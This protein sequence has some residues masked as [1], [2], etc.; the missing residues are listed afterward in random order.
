MS[1]LRRMQHLFTIKHKQAKQSSGWQWVLPGWVLAR[2]CPELSHA[3]EC[4]LAPPDMLKDCTSTHRDT[5]SHN[6]S[7]TRHHERACNTIRS[8]ELRFINQRSTRR[9]AQHG[10]CLSTCGACACIIRNYA[11]FGNRAHGAMRAQEALPLVRSPWQAR[12]A[13]RT[14]SARELGS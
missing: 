6:S 10:Q 4:F 1:N 5:G 14:C 7:A 9:A 13:A 2:V 8:W 12:R 11:V 3:Y